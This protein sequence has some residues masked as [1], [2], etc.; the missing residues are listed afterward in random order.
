M[1]PRDSECP[2][3]LQSTLASFSLALIELTKYSRLFV[4]AG[5]KKSESFL[6]G[7]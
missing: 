6:V 7:L 1:R 2:S 4:H 3:G 5:C